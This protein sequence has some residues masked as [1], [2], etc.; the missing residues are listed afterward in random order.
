M[1]YRVTH[2]V[3]AGG[4]SCLGPA[5]EDTCCYGWKMAVDHRAETLY[6]AQAPELLDMLARTKG[7]AFMR[8]DAR[9][10]RCVAFEGG[11]CGIERRHG[12]SF[13]ND[14]CHFYPR[15]FH[16][17]GDFIL[18]TMAPSCPESA[19]LALFG[20]NGFA[21]GATELPRLPLALTDHTPAGMQPAS[22]LSLHQEIIARLGALDA[23]PSQWLLRL[24]ALAE[25]IQALPPER[26]S[27]AAMLYLEEPP[28]LMPQPVSRPDEMAC[29]MHA[30]AGLAAAAHQAHYPRLLSLI[31]VMQAQ[32]QAK[33]A[34]DRL[35][36][37][38]LPGSLHAA[39]HMRARWVEE[40]SG[41]F[42]AA[43]KNYLLIELSLSCFPFS[44]FGESLRDRVTILG[45]RF[46]TVRLGLMCLCAE[47]PQ[48]SADRVW[49]EAA[50]VRVVQS[51]SRLLDHLGAAEYSLMLYE[52]AGWRRPERWR[53]LIKD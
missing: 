36:L 6:R 22:A 11:W 39:R 5:C 24:Y 19:R 18:M 10:G 25:A 53:A 35:T 45:V 2:P 13:M 52:S 32:L 41:L 7:E 15:L 14:A 9:T 27:D 3:F 23:S 37:S 26:W 31:D 12:A 46:A 33:I 28:P 51:V 16:R 48:E 42:A 40:W 44:G 34:W 21:F 20:E 8:H 47:S 43:L 1:G 17:F 50:M 38:L 49:R 4:F 30:L 29:V